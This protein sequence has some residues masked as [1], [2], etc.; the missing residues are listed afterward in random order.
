MPPVWFK[1]SALV[2]FPAAS[3]VFTSPAHYGLTSTEY[4]GMFVPQAIMAIVASLLAAELQSR[5]GTKRI[6]LLGLLANLL[7]MTLLVASR[8]V[9]R[10]TALAYGILL[11]A[12]DLHGDWLWFYRP[13]AQYS[14]RGLFP[15]ERGQGCAR[16]ERAPGIG[17]G[18]G[19]GLRRD[20]LSGWESGGACP[21]SSAC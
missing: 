3:A 10:N 12:T 21:C 6:Y 17:N 13:G 14:G 19:P 9:M 2:T 15:A 11:I 4:G 8:F 7:A 1:A 16:A 5:L 18:A 20:S